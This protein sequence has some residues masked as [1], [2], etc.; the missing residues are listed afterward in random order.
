MAGITAKYGQLIFEVDGVEHVSKARSIENILRKTQGIQ[1]A[2]VSESGHISLKFEKAVT[3]FEIIASVLEKQGLTIRNN[4]LTSIDLTIRPKIKEHESAKKRTQNKED[5]LNIQGESKECGHDHGH[6]NG[7]FF[8]RNAELIF[9]V[10]SG[11]LLVAGFT[12]S[13]VEPVREW[14]SLVFYIGAYFFGGFYTAKEAFETI[15]KGG[16]EIDFLMLVAAIG[17]AILGEWAEGALLL[18]LFSLGHALEHYAMNKARK[19]IAALANLSPKTAL[20]KQKC[21]T[22]V[23]PVEALKIGDIILVK[24]HSRISA[25]GVVVRGSSSVNEAPLTGE[26]VPVEKIALKEDQ[27]DS[28]EDSLVDKSNRVFAGTINGNYSLEIRVTKLAKDSTLARMVQL[29]N[30]AQTPKIAHPAAYKQI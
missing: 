26:S 30:E 5:S 8:S 18:F 7:G 23:V 2:L 24:P 9:S 20:L 3:T 1:E 21:T 10:I 15:L 28:R 13:F 25:D 11:V 17:A 22:E 6:T 27:P 16:F 4:T 12:L 19:S 14:L 29:V